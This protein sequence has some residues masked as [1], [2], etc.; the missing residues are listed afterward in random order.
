VP[1]VSGNDLSLIIGIDGVGKQKEKRVDKPPMPE[2]NKRI[3]RKLDFEI[4]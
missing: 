3:P 1:I 4:R 2:Y